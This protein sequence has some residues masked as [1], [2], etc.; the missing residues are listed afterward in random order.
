MTAVS[1]E[2]HSWSRPK[3]AAMILLVLALQVA[4]IYFLSNRSPILPRAT[5][6]TPML[7]LMG[8]G[9]EE[10]QWLSLR[11]PTL[12]VLPHEHGFS[13]QAWLRIPPLVYHPFEWREPLRWLQLPAEEL[14]AF[15]TNL[16]RSETVAPI[17]FDA[18][19]KPEITAPDV[20]LISLTRAPTRLRVRGELAGRHLVK[21]LKLP[22]Q[23]N[24]DILGNSVVQVLVDGNGNVLSATLLPPGSGLAAADQEAVNLAKSARF[25]PLDHGETDALESS[26]TNLTL[27]DMVFQWQTLAPPMTN[28]PSATTNT[29]A[30]VAIP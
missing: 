11:D 6:T 2:L 18:K 13:G 26:G 9:S 3:W 27:G 25:E 7:R 20:A 16:V 24:G 17:Q 14:G 19:P 12:F 4:C 23:T 28:A 8:D 1:S 30:R 21:P 5:V 29:P 22:T 10:L 15:F